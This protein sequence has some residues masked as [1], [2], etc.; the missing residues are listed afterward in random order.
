MRTESGAGV[1][2]AQ[3]GPGRRLAQRFWWPAQRRRWRRTGA[4]VL[5]LAALLVGL[6]FALASGDV[7]RACG[8]HSAACGLGINSAVTA[9]VA[10]AG[11]LY[12]TAFRRRR[13][14]G[15]YL[16]QATQEPERLF[17]IPPN[18]VLF[19]DMVGRDELYRL[20]AEELRSS[21]GGPQLLLGDVGSGKT[22][23]LL[24]LTSYL[25]ER[26]AVPIPISLRGDDFPLSLRT[27]A[28]DHFLSQIDGDVRSE[29]EADRIWRALCAEGSIVVL[30]DG[31]DEATQSLTTEERTITARAALELA[32]SQ[33]IPM[34]V[35]SRQEGAP[36]DGRYAQFEF[37]PLSRDEALEYVRKRSRQAQIA[38]EPLVR[39][40]L[41][42]A[43]VAATPFYL[44]VIAALLVAH[45]LPA[46]LPE[47]VAGRR[48]AE[49]QTLV[50]VALLD[51]YVTGAVDGSVR[52]DPTLTSEQRR[53]TV[54][55]LERIAGAM[56][57][58]GE[59]TTTVSAV[60]EA[61]ATLREAVSDLPKVDVAGAV[62][63]GARLG[64]MQLS[65][66]QAERS[67]RFTH[68]IVQSYFT[69]RLFLRHPALSRPL[70]AEVATTELMNALSM[71]CAGEDG[72]AP[73]RA[74][75]VAVALV[76][77]A[78]ERAEDT[79]LRLVTTAVTLLAALGDERVESV[80]ALA[81]RA[82]D[83]A[84]QAEKLSAIPRLGLVGTP[85]TWRFLLQRTDDPDYAV[86]WAAGRSIV[87]GGAEAY[88]AL[89]A[90]ITA[91]MEYATATPPEDWH[92]PELHR[93]AVLGWLLPALAT[94]ADGP[95][96]QE[97]RGFV[98][99]LV[100]TAV[101][102]PTVEASLAQGFKLDAMR[103]PAAA[104][105]LE[106]EL[107]DR[108]RYW[109]SR[110]ILLQAICIRYVDGTP[111]P[112]AL[113]AL[114]T[115]AADGAEHPFVTAAA[116]LCL[117]AVREGDYERYVWDDDTAA[118]TRSGT[119]LSREA[120]QL[121]GDIV[122]LLNLTEQGDRSMQL[123]R[124]ALTAGRT[125]LPSC[126]GRG[127]GREALDADCPGPPDCGF[128]LC[129]YPRL[130]SA[131]VCRGALSEAFCRH[132]A[133]LIQQGK[134]GR[135]QVAVWQQPDSRALREFWER[136]A[137]RSRL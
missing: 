106:L 77:Q 11:F 85:W 22:T 133:R 118:T 34:V 113:W 98:G 62:E 71:W 9:A 69:R 66:R 14:V 25:A 103:S 137:E 122:L 109:Y 2:A 67:V 7:D 89:R 8:G 31:L 79:G 100:G 82:W 19:K 46:G 97:L 99:A 112:R 78:R 23:F 128:G 32:R 60:A 104:E 121:A 73:E 33:P 102:R 81:R 42:A 17:P 18:D 58:G 80:G 37:Q 126:L 96:R 92:D 86:R 54:A 41:D 35:T 44:N 125:D 131:A 38:D 30:A 6:T 72:D 134:L 55:H 16:R 27:L 53:R 127:S 124:L 4:A 84:G 21:A 13:T 114:R 75:A 135:R 74:E 52:T 48:F 136:M 49:R 29:Q 107:L 91:L 70:L 63:N 5:V 120:A 115:R 24:G 28:H 43:D 93:T 39:W 110:V 111:D 45:R 12:F 61:D 40:I 15:A 132:Q 88:G 57:F 108:A 68:A 90:E 95:D 117:R 129:P 26:G 130:A 56:T 10:L 94:A 105:P 101:A 116:K 65:T 51:A 87:D 123:E 64:L 36:P 59:L 50:R 47:Q 83:V 119:A 76:A 20:I 3:R 1:G